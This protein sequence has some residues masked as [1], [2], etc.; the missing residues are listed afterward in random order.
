MTTK[1]RLA[2]HITDAL[3]ASAGRILA[4]HPDR[5]ELVDQLASWLQTAHQRIVIAPRVDRRSD[6]RIDTR[7]YTL[8]IYLDTT[9]GLA[10]LVDVRRRDLLIPD[11][12]EHEDAQAECRTLLLQLGY[13]VP[14]DASQ[15]GTK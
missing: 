8:G 13:G 2:D 12:V 3:A 15:L 5:P 11:G 10:P 4:A 7:S 14:D 1:Q 6:G 9:S